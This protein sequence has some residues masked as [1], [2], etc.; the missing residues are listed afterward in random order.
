MFVDRTVHASR[1]RPGKIERDLRGSR[2]RT[3][4]DGQHRFSRPGRTIGWCLRENRALHAR[5][6]LRPSTSGPLSGAVDHLQSFAGAAGAGIVA[7][8][9]SPRFITALP[10]DLRRLVGLRRHRRTRRP[11]ILDSDLV[12]ALGAMKRDPPAICRCPQ[13]TEIRSAG[14]TSMGG[15]G[16]RA[17]IFRWLCLVAAQ[18]ADRGLFLPTTRSTRPSNRHDQAGG[19]R[20]G[21]P[22]RRSSPSVGGSAEKFWTPDEAGRHAGGSRPMRSD[23][24]SQRPV[25][26][27][28]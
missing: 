18:G 26:R 25:R 3:Y 24:M 16:N 27:R 4:D 9:L 2:F 14:G 10:L 7:D 1:P 5:R 22:A 19:V 28:R 15:S 8:R 20:Q 12:Q 13:P 23:C 21:Q 17:R 6:P 11:A